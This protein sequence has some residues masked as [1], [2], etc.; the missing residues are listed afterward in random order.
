MASK[1]VLDLGSLN[2]ERP[3][4]RIDGS[5]YRMKVPM[6]IDLVTLSR[7]TG[8]DQ[9]L[10]PKARKAK[11]TEKDARELSEAIDEGVGLIMYDKIPGEVL[12]KLNEIAKLAILDA[13]PLASARAGSQPNRAARRRAARAKPRR[14]TSAA[15]SRA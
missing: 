13:F 3:F 12:G 4:I 11:P 1:P 2:P 10:A 5:P 14:S 8:I 9:R 15:S 7:L 6:D